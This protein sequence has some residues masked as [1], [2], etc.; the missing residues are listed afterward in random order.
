MAPIDPDTTPAL[1]NIL[2]L[3]KSTGPLAEQIDEACQILGVTLPL[4]GDEPKTLDQSHSHYGPREEWTMRWLLKKL[5]GAGSGIQNIYLEPKVWLLFQ[6]L[7]RCF[8]VANLARLL[9]TH[10]F[11]KVLSE[12]IKAL[13]DVLEK[14]KQDSVPLANS[15]SRKSSGVLNSS[16]ATVETTVKS[17]TTSRKRK[18]DGTLVHQ[19]EKIVPHDVNVR[20]IH[21]EITDL[22]SELLALKTEDAYGYACE[23]LKMAMRPSPDEAAQMLG[24]SMTIANWFIH[25]PPEAGNR[26]H[27]GSPHWN[28]ACWFDMWDSRSSREPELTTELAFSSSCLIPSLELLASLK[29]GLVHIREDDDTIAI[30]ERL[31]LKH[32]VSPVRQSFEKSRS[33]AR[34]SEEA[35]EVNVEE[36]LSLLG[37]SHVRNGQDGGSKHDKMHPIAQFYAIVLKHTPLATPKQRLSEKAW[38]QF[39]FDH[40]T[41]QASV[42]EIELS[43]S[44]LTPDPIRA[45]KDMLAMLADHKVKLEVSALEKILEQRSHIF[46]NNEDLQVD[47]ELVGL[48]LKIDPDV[49]V[50]PAVS[51]DHAD[52]TSRKPNEYL[53]SVCKKINAATQ[54]SETMPEKLRQ[55]IEEV[56]LIP[57]VDAFS[58]ARNFSGFV[59]LWRSNLIQAHEHAGTPEAHPANDLDPLVRDSRAKSDL[60]LWRSERL[61]QAV[62]DRVEAR[63]TVGQM[64]AILSKPDPSTATDL[65]ILDC[66]LSGCKNEHTIE[67][68]SETVKIVYRTL[69]GSC[70]VDHMCVEEPWRVWRCLATIE[71][72]WARDMI[73]DT[74]DEELEA[75]I[76]SKALEQQ[77][78][79]GQSHSI[80]E[81]LQSLNFV[82]S[83]ID[84]LGADSRREAA[85]T[86]VHAIMTASE[87]Y[88]EQI[89]TESGGHDDLTASP[90][91]AKRCA[92]MM[93]LVRNYM[94]Q[95]CLRTTALRAATPELQKRFFENLLACALQD[96]KPGG[97]ASGGLD[98]DPGLWH[99]F[100]HS[101]ALEEDLALAKGFEEF[102]LASFLLS[103]P[104]RN[105]GSAYAF[106]FDSIHRTFIH[107]FN[108]RQRANI[109]NRVLENLCQVPSLTMRL[110]KD[111]VKLLI[112]YLANP[113]NSFNLLQHPSGLPNASWGPGHPKP[114]LIKIAQVWDKRPDWDG[115]AV[116]LLKRFTGAVLE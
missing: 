82:L 80:D 74:N 11:V 4:P 98:S 38:L 99:D 81:L 29:N 85:F 54:A 16:S 77:I 3:D 60:N 27:M 95:L 26:K 113:N 83:V 108:R 84:C 92:D 106:L 22:V 46:D 32:V 8:P 102:L 114:A 70:E 48:C 9:R 25:N 72:R 40:L 61:L 50:I 105:P 91:S 62:A 88:S 5:E 30:L 1:R 101:P 21:N 87:Y 109:F 33:C 14:Q 43:E 10:G 57:L 24:I 19:L 93:F 104:N 13:G 6:E 35:P 76:A 28:M 23:H 59:D 115:E 42:L 75:K 96:S 12:A 112:T 7:I 58:Q 69:L 36:L 71:S 63:L 97:S 18:H 103:E 86:A 39:L 44:P 49:F 17:P 68:L 89:K 66:I 90:Q 111:H 34:K 45:S 47:W 41:K 53:A 64:Q 73:L 78:Q 2:S 100:L 110:G 79:L 107:A 94:S 55:K 67:Q 37:K 56:I 65:V 51:K 15:A 52:R 116:Q 31:L 20:Y